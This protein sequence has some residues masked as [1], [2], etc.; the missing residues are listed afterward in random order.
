M[1]IAWE[2]VIP[3]MFLPKIAAFKN[4]IFDRILPT[5]DLIDNE[6]KQVEKDT[7][8]RLSLSASEYTDESDV[9]EASLNA[10]ISHFEVLTETRQAVINAFVV[11][12][13]HLFEQQKHL[14]ACNTLL[15]SEPNSKKRE[16]RYRELLSGYE[17]NESGFFNLKKLE[18][19]KIVA[20]AIK[21]GEGQ[22]AERLRLLRPDLFVHPCV[23]HFPGPMEDILGPIHRPL[24]GDDLFVQPEDL[25]GY[26][27][28]VDE[29]WRYVLKAE[30]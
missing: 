24:M 19:L 29:Y 21:H 6:A 1:P 3:R 26:L 9:E 18:E 30:G 7:Y 28:A 2:D 5:L 27:D 14:L 12:I 15:D 23:R 13:A 22:S 20:D 16:E 8:E 11:A 25:S 17:V 10:A 4:A